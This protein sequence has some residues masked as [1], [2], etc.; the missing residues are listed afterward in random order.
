MN[1]EFDPDGEDVPSS[2]FYNDVY[3]WGRGSIGQV[4]VIF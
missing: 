3:M 2:F 4:S 1:S